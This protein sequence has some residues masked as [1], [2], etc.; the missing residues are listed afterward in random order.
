MFL[1]STKTCPN[2]KMAK[3]YLDEAKID[4]SVKYAEDDP[5]YCTKNEIQTAPT[6]VLNDGTKIENVSNI[7]KWIKDNE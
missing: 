4:Y 2:C 3:K 7:R 6:L 5:E 1:I